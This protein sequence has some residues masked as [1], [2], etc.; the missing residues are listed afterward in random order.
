MYLST[1]T[2]EQSDYY[3]F[4]LSCS[5][6]S[7]ACI[8]KRTAPYFFGKHI[9]TSF[10]VYLITSG[11]CRM[12]INGTDLICDK[13]DFIMILPNTVHSF[14]V[15]EDECEFLHIHFN[16][17]I[18]S[19]ILV[20]KTSEFS[21]SLTDALL[22]HCNFYYRQPSNILLF[23]L[24]TSIVGIYKRN[25][26][27]ACVSTNLHLAQLMLYILEQVSKNSPLTSNVHA[28]NHYIAYTLQYISEH[29]QTKLLVSDI[30]ETL[31]ISSRYLSKIFSQHMHLTLA[32]YINIYRINQAIHLMET[33]N[34]PLV[35][36]ALAI[37]LKDSQHFSRLFVKII[38]TTPGK[39]RKLIQSNKT[40]S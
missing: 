7:G 29:Y 4:N 8:Q 30:A 2:T 26:N 14:E 15:P 18:F 34:L 23:N 1:L 19:H 3:N 12:N 13:N 38:N 24:V 22:F 5:S 36:I 20:K 21:I 25:E 32:N 6:I 17:D 37:G 27:F 31:N 33:T 10:E 16:P 9:H 35:D 40:H 39:Y 28:Q 11:H